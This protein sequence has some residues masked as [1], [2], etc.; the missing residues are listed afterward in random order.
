LARKPSASDPASGLP[1][2]GLPAYGLPAS[3]LPGADLN[4]PLLSLGSNE[5]HLW[6]HP[7]RDAAS[8][9]A[10]CRQV[11]SRYATI[12]AADW[13]FCR[14]ANGK[15]ALEG[16]P[17]DLQFNLSDSGDWL[18]CAIAMGTAVGVDLEYCDPGRDVLKLARRCF[19]PAEIS[20]MQ[21][22]DDA[23]QSQ[24]FY[25]YWTLKEASIKSRG[26]SLGRELES[27]AFELL[28]SSC[29]PK[30]AAVVRAVP[31]DRDFYCLL[32]P[33]PDYRL[34]VC[35]H[36]A[37]NL[38]QRLRLFNLAGECSEQELPLVMRASSSRES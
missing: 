1:A 8:S 20:D 38:Q 24:R 21:A 5:L 18:A 16:A 14:N 25:D 2:Y 23:E 26:G 17:L 3:G 30:S 11:L 4:P 7:L 19:S 31:A 10:F 28:R 9:D 27:T 22:C 6:L 37:T 29:D 36:G 15:P 12:A 32:D 34:A 33:L 35:R 13:R